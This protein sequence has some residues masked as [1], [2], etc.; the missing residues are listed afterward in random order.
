[1]SELRP[2]YF[3][4]PFLAVPAALALILAGSL[5]AVRPHP[6]RVASKAAE[7]TLAQLDAAARSGDPASFFEMGRKA[8]L[9]T[10]AARWQISPDQITGSELQARL[11]AAGEDV[12]RLFAL[13]DEAKYSKYE[14]G[15]TDFQRW[16]KVIR[17]Q[18]LGERR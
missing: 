4:A 5:L 1:V 6:G 11:G 12:E 14:A 8:L 13:A 17:A 16:L 10:F 7:R 3:Q 18:L 2:L 9:R 15:A